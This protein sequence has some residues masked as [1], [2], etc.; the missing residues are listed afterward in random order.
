MLI[1]RR[2]IYGLIFIAIIIE[3]SGIFQPLLRNDDPVLYAIIAK[4]MAVSNNWVDLFMNGTPWLDK[5]HFPFWATALSFKIFGISAFSYNLPGFLFFVLGGIYTYRV[6]KLLY[7]SDVALVSI[8]IYF[9]SLHLM[10]SATID[11]RAEAYML[12]Q[13]I[14]ACY[15]WLRYDGKFSFR[16]LIL[17]SL[18]TALAMMT[19][20]PFVVITI[21]S[22]IVI[23]W[24]YMRQFKKIISL[25]WVLAYLLTLLFI[26]P[27]IITL[28]LQFD[29]HP[30]VTVFGRQGVSG[31]AWYFWG[32][33][34]GR[35]FNSGPIVNKHGDFFFFFHTYLWAFIPWSIL[36]IV[37][38]WDMIK[39]FRASRDNIYKAK[40]VYL[41]ASFGIT[42]LMFSLTKFQL[43]HYTNIIMPFAAIICA[44]FIETKIDV[45]WLSIVQRGIS[46]IILFGIMF[47]S[48][49]LFQ[50]QYYSFFAIIPILML[51]I[52]IY[53]RKR[54]YTDHLL[55]L[56]SLTVCSVLAFAMFVNVFIC[57]KYDV[58]YQAA[59]IVNRQPLP[60][61]YDVNTR[62]TP[63]EFNSVM[64]YKALPDASSLPT[65]GEYY[66]FMTQS[67]W[68]N[69]VYSLNN[70]FK[71][72]ASFCGNN[73]YK[74]LPYY[75]NKDVL[76]GHLECYT[77]IRHDS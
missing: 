42:F 64:S 71:E 23:T 39:N 1:N 27:E 22:G 76:Q 56:P 63:L 2:L 44:Q 67:D 43:D 51:G 74:V 4:N 16:Y 57:A 33:Q 52:A 11:L 69:N 14:P 66:V 75:A 46:I 9:T 21:F 17:G 49:Y 3:V 18:F 29:A 50:G 6:A 58:G 41:W 65:T 13:I 28:Y 77:I 47:L 68:M 24:I 54:S 32:S 70:K 53:A 59:Q 7:S 37:A 55:L 73:L 45:R 31:I 36:Y 8:L 25:K 20:G 35:F 38:L 34:F 72:V 15:Y 60:M 5:P 40:A 12:G 30:E 48:V 10:M 19:K 62:M 26:A 61:I